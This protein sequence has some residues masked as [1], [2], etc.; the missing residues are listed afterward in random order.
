VSH[1]FLTNDAGQLISPD[2]TVHRGEVVYLNL[3]IKNGWMAVKGKVTLGATQRIESDKGEPILT[4]GD[5]FAHQQAL[6]KKEA[7]HLQLQA[8]ITKS[9]P[10]IRFVTISFRVW[11]KSGPAEITGSYRLSLARE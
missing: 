7:R 3:A 10:D 6:T 5:L 1:A 8:V 11:D 9:R 2:R 4:S